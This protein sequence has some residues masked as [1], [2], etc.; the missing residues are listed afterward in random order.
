M[1]G[2]VERLKVTHCRIQCARN[3]KNAHEIKAL[4]DEGRQFFTSRA[5]KKC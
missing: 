5:V 3:M 1:T 4:L 2:K